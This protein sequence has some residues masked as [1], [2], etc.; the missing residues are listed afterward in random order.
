[1]DKEANPMDYFNLIDKSVRKLDSFIRD[2][3]DFS[4]NARLEIEPNRV[5]F[6]PL[7]K[8][9][10]E[11]VHF[12]E[13]YSKFRQSVLIHTRKDFQ[14]DS[15]RIRII[16]SNLISNAIKHHLERENI[17]PE[18]IIEIKDSG[19]GVNIT[20]KDN[21]PGIEEKYLQN[22]FKMFFR[23]TDRTPGSGLGLYIVEETVTKLKGT[24]TV[25]SVIDQGTTFTVFLPNLHK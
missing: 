5:E 21:G 12:L 9:I 15:K 22:I 16:L 24:I 23:A 13:N 10:F 3:I 20:V 8:D 19:K 14:S 17:T 25:S 18:V 11:D 2:I 4:R 7:I 6:E 1:M